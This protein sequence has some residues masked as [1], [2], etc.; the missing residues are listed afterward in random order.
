[1]AN[2]YSTGEHRYMLMYKQWLLFWTKVISW[3]KMKNN[4]SYVKH[5]NLFLLHVHPF[6]PAFYFCYHVLSV[7]MNHQKRH[8]PNWHNNFQIGRFNYYS[9]SKYKRPSQHH[10]VL[11]KRKVTFQIFIFVLITVLLH[12]QDLG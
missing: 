1:M 5:L 7:T 9:F 4:G 3:L 12:T 2:G 10:G 8:Q 6:V 11:W